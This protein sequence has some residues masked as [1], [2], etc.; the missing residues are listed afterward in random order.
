[1]ILIEEKTKLLFT[2]NIYLIF[3]PINKIILKYIDILNIKLKVKCKFFI[4]LNDKKE[5]LY[6]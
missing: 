4:I 1:M 6:R 2:K 5:V 3:H